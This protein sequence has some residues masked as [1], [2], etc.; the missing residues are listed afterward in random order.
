M[1][2]LNAK[3]ALSTMLT[4]AQDLHSAVITQDGALYVFGSDAK[5]QLG[6]F[7]SG[8]EPTLVEVGDAEESAVVEQPDF[9]SV[10]CGSAH[11]AAVTSKGHLWVAGNSGSAHL[12]FSSKGRRT[13][14][15]RR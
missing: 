1:L 10:G 11:T 15:S 8:G 3:G 2:L 7:S 13:N 5:G 4:H 12:L 14:Q 9:I 6:G